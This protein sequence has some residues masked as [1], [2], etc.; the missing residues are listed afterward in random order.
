MP[1]VLR[2]PDADTSSDRASVGIIACC[3]VRMHVEYTAV[4]L[5]GARYKDDLARYVKA[6]AEVELV[7]EPDNPYD[8]NA[9]LVLAV[10]PSQ[11]ESPVPI[12]YLAKGAASKVARDMDAGRTFGAVFVGGGVDQRPY[13]VVLGAGDGEDLKLAKLRHR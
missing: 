9:V 4:K 6:G 1:G 12:G 10:V 8:S 11:G 3:A 2:R 5:R 7:R 13:V